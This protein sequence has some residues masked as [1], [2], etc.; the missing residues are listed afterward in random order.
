MHEQSLVRQLLRQVD[1][2]CRV[3]GAECVSEV[4]VE[5]GPMAGVDP[6][7]LASAFE[8]LAPTSTARGAKLVIDEVTLQARCNCCDDE[9]EVCDFV[10][11]CPTCGGNVRV[12]R[13]DELQLVSV[14]LRSAASSEESIS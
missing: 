14:S 9:F 1:E 5:A 13:G 6:T 12:I 8:Q 11:R 3:H 10:F 7:L 2:I 4:V